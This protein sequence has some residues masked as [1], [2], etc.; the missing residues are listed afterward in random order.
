MSLRKIFGLPLL[1]FS[2]MLSGI[3]SN[4][5]TGREDSFQN[6]NWELVSE[7]ALQTSGS[8]VQSICATDDYIICLE[9]VSDSPSDADIVSAYYKN[10][11]DE[12]G[13]PVTRYSLARQTN[14]TC[15]EHGNGMAYNPKTNEIYVSLYTNS[16]PENRG[17]IYVMD[18]DTLEFKRSIKISDDYNILGIGYREETNQYVIQTN[19]EGGYSF[20]LLDENFQIVEDL[21]EYASTAKVDNFQ[22]LAVCGDYILNFPLTLFSGMGDF[23]H[24]YSISERQMIADPAI[25][26]HFEG[27]TSDE[28]ESLC[29]IAPGE[30]LAAVNVTKEDGSR[31][32]QFYRVMIPSLFYLSS[33]C[34]MN[35]TSVIPAEPPSASTDISASVSTDASASR[36]SAGQSIGLLFAVPAFLAI[37]LM[38][39]VWYICYVRLQRERKRKHMIARRKRVQCYSQEELNEISDVELNKI[40]KHSRETRIYSEIA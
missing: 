17:C 25:D 40:I 33:P 11:T 4:A 36:V 3:T 18:P 23:L 21:G 7:H 2:L 1:S 38:A 26:F 28:P 24:V 39:T 35:H 13:N 20:K 22:D 14:S 16:V 29:E 12:N 5:E 10:E 9:N 6:L 27:I 37:L 19:V 8:V 34:Y 32:L 31:C 15:W 30:F